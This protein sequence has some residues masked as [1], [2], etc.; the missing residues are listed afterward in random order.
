MKGDIEWRGAIL[1]V[2]TLVSIVVI[3]AAGARLVWWILT[4]GDL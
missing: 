4:G 1:A 3:L 2:L